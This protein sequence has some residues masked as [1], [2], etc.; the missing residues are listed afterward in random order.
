[1]TRSFPLFRLLTL[2]LALAAGPAHAQHGVPGTSFDEVSGEIGTEPLYCADVAAGQRVCTWHEREGTHV[3]CGFDAMGG[4]TAVPCLRRADNTSMEVFP[5][6]KG[7]LRKQKKQ[8]PR[9]PLRTG[10][11]R[12]VDGAADIWAVTDL[13]GAGPVSCRSADA[14]ICA[15]FATR[16][17]PGYVTLARFAN[18]PGK[19]IGMVCTF[20][21]DGT[22]SAGSCSAEAS[23]RAPT[24]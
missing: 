23:G 9:E 4:R 12:Q 14:L 19:K 7:P 11:A 16:R 10:A 18:A 8:P 22:R 1:M 20:Q 24:P 13:V 3:V 17:T 21:P 2:L 15:W 5:G 6:G